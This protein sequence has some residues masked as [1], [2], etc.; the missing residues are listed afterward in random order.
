MFTNGSYK[1]VKLLKLAIPSKIKR[2]Y[3][4]RDN[5]EKINSVYMCMIMHEYGLDMII[6]TFFEKIFPN[7]ALKQI[8]RF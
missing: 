2:L 7:S 1:N 6:S 5:G 3:D 4:E 8:F